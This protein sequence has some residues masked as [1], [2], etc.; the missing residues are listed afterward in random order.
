MTPLSANDRTVVHL[1]RHG[2]VANPQ[3]ILYG[4]LPG[5]GL[6][7]L[8]LRMA[9]LAAAHL[10]DRD[11]SVV[12]SSPLE[13]ARQTAAPIAAVHGLPVGIDERVIEAENAFEG[14]QVAGGK[15]ILRDPSLYKYLLNPMRPSWGEP[16]TQLAARMQRAVDD[17]RHRVAG[18]EGVIVSHQ[19]PIWMLRSAVENRRLWH[20]PR[21][22]E[23]SLASVTTLTYAGG[24][25]A[26]IDYSEPAAELLPMAAPGA[27]A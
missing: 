20:D 23:C 11:V 26:S 21:K 9:D 14:R 2:E 25:L 8:G 27:G 12:V 5:Y 22:R 6:S 4:R 1:V 24:V 18:H 17:L 3:R 13:R 16:Y 10:S 19:A 15:G 7:E